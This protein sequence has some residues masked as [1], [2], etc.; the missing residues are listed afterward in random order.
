MLRQLRDAPAAS[1]EIDDLGRRSGGN[2]LFLRALLLAPGPSAEGAP[3][4]L[5]AAV[6][7]HLA[8]LSVAARATLRDA[9]V[10]GLVVDREL[11]LEASGAQPR[12]WDAHLDQAH[13]VGL[14]RRVGPGSWS[15]THGLVWETL[16]SEVPEERRTQIHARILRA[17]E[18][19][20][21]S[22]PARLATLADH[23]ARGVPVI[24]PA[25]AAR[26]C[27]AAADAS[28]R[29][30][31][32]EEADRL[33]RLALEHTR[34]DAE[35]LELL[36]TL[37]E[38]SARLADLAGV[39]AVRAETL[40]LA[41]RLGDGR[42]HARAT[43]ALITA[44]GDM[45]AE[46]P[47][48][49]TL[50]RIDTALASHSDPTPERARLLIRLAEFTWFMPPR[51]R[52]L[53]AARSALDLARRCGDTDALA[54]ALVH[55]FR[56]LQTGVGDD[57]VREEIHGDLVRVADRVEESL[58]RMKALQTLCWNSMMRGDGTGLGRWVL[59][60]E[61]EARATGSPQTLWWALVGRTS[62]AHLRGEFRDAE[63]LAE[64]GR[65]LGS[66][67]GFSMTERNFALQMF[68]IRW[69]QGRL[70]EI[71]DVLGGFKAATPGRLP[72][73]IAWCH[74]GVLNGRPGPARELLRAVCD[75]GLR[76]VQDDVSQV[77]T[78]TM[79]AES[80]A[81]LGEPEP[82]RVVFDR[83]RAASGRHAVVA[84]GFCHRGSVAGYLGQLCETFDDLD[85]AAHWYATGLERDRALGA[86]PFVAR[87]QIGL[88]RVLVRIGGDSAE[89]GLRL[90]DEGVGLGRDLGIH[91][92]DAAAEAARA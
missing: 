67:I 78:F 83:L 22:D 75:E 41:E 65:A 81:L 13:A 91:G 17:L 12:T 88:G 72:W 85:G 7:A 10:L 30:L 53:T 54:D 39:L 33:F 25:E 5:P 8:T 3:T 52:G 70:G 43:L 6:S 58:L 74:A 29:R 69:D 15:F 64:E 9:S 49:E 86:L 55:G 27:A 14:V 44:R 71:E 82:A 51:E 60:M 89:R 18:K 2:P 1:S 37:A 66:S 47:D 87:G 80:S 11:A 19:R 31:A 28:A 73:E 62:R 24:P 42:A 61:E 21:G 35:R 79:L 76:R 45:S 63:E 32:F 36:V 92:L 34:A 38:N 68:A 4:A 50:G 57:A 90:L 26:R 40:E 77:D 59:R 56:V 46:V 20:E 23:A 48:A 84:Q 16:W